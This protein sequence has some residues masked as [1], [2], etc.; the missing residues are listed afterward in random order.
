MGQAEN[1]LA[2]TKI[3]LTLEYKTESK[4]NTISSLASAFS[5]N[6]PTLPLLLPSL[7]S[8]PPIIPL[9]PYTMSQQILVD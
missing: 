1:T 5:S 9:L 7:S 4:S 2:P 6:P 3:S 8:L